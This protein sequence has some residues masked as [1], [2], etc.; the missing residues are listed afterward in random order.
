MKTAENNYPD[1][2]LTNFRQQLAQ[3][4]DLLHSVKNSLQNIGGLLS[5]LAL[6]C[7]QQGIRLQSMEPIRLELNETVARL[8]EYLQQ[9]A[10]AINISRC[11]LNQLIRETAQSRQAQLT[12][13]QINLQ[14]QLAEDLPTL[15]LDK[16]GLQKVLLNCLDNSQAAILAK[17]QPGGQIIIS[18]R[19]TDDTVQI[20]LEDNGCGLTME[21]QARIFTPYYTTKNGGS[22]IGT[23]ISQAVV[24][25][26]GGSIS[27]K[28]RPGIGCRVKIELP[29][30]GRQ[31]FN[32]DD[33]YSEIANMLL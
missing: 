5:I 32:S 18:T 26:H 13:R 29:V 21:Q 4:M 10:K 6:K 25:L 20:L 9:P 12:A 30:Q 8:T 1:A 2:N 23:A 15:Y 17:A 22:G 33:L 28:G 3:N 16:P 19:R 24:K 7:D 31:N 27:A 11:S 14:T